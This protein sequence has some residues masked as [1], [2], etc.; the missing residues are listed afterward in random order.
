VLTYLIGP[1]LALFPR[2]WRRALPSR[3]QVEWRPA[4]ALSGFAEAALALTAMMYWYSYT[5]TT[6]VDRGWDA[7]LSGKMPAGV[8]DHQLGFAALVIF[9]SHPLTWAIAYFG[10]EGSVRLLGAT[11]SGTSLGILPLFVVDKVFGKI[12]GR[13][14]AKTG[15]TMETSQGNVSSYLG[16]VGDSVMTKFLRSVPDEL[17][18]V[19]N[20]VEEILEIRACRKKTDWIPPRVV[21]YQDAYYRLEADSRGMAPRPFH[22]Q[23]RRLERGVPGRNVLLYSPEQPLIREKT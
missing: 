21:R 3:L 14:H 9:A 13:A 8:T 22:Y 23:L 18:F 11:A 16:A 6:W 5:M 17:S 20:E 2:R 7:A 10:V 4:T 1:I 15:V 12:T 19:R